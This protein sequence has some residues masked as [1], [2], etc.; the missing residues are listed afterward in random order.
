MRQQQQHAREDLGRQRQQQL[1]LRQQ[2][3]A[4][5]AICS[6]QQMQQMHPRE[7]IDVRHRVCSMLRAHEADVRFRR[8]LPQIL[9]WRQSSVLITKEAAKTMT[10]QSLD[11]ERQSQ[12]IQS[13]ESQPTQA[14]TERPIWLRP[15]ATDEAATLPSLEHL[16]QSRRKAQFWLP[17]RVP[18]G[19]ATTIGDDDEIAV[20]EDDGDK[21]A[22]N[23][24]RDWSRLLSGWDSEANDGGVP[25]SD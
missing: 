8:N 12:A 11:R 14:V 1:S 5:A 9:A 2:Q 19:A 7:Q 18:E 15:W 20:D 25:A 10:Q 23:W 17:R 6:M 16:E 4:S 13:H 21:E 24:L 22:V 3:I